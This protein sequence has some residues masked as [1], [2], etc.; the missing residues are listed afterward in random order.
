MHFNIGVL[1]IRHVRDLGPRGLKVSVGNTLL[2]SRISDGALM[3]PRWSREHNGRGR[4]G[5]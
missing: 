5:C 4:R 2:R 1:Y 3:H